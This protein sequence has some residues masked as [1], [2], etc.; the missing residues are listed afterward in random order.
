MEPYFETDLGKLFNGDALEV[1]SGMESESVQCCITSPPYWGLRDYGTATWEGGDL[2]CNHEK[3]INK[4]K[5]HAGTGLNVAKNPEKMQTEVGGMHSHSYRD[6]CKKCGAKRIDQQL[7]LEK[8]PEEY[9]SKMV[10]IF[11]EVRRVLRKDGTLWLNLG[12]SYYNNFGGGSETMTTGNAP[13]VKARGR[14]N[15]PKHKTLKIK[16]LCGIPWRVAFALQADGWWLRQD[17]IW[18]LSGGTWIYARTQKGDMPMMLKDLY[19]LNPSTIKLWN[20]EKWTQLLGM[21]KAARTG[22]EIELVL[23]SGER[24]SCTG[25]HKFPTNRGLLEASNIKV[26]DCLE[27]TFIP[28]PTLPKKPKHITYDAAWFAGLYLAE[29]SKSGN[30]IQI[31]GHAK[32]QDRWNR[33]CNIVKDYGGYITRTISGNKMDIRIW[34]NVLHAILDELV[35]GRT[36]K[37]KCLSTTCWNYS[38]GF[39]K[40]L[41][42]GYLSGDGGWDESN[43]RWRLGFT[44][45]YNLERDIRVLAARLEFNLT[46]NLSNSFIKDKKYPSFRGEIKFEATAEGHWNQK[47]KLEVVEIR[48][49][50]CRYVYDIGVEDSHLFA[51][52]SGVLTH[53]SKPNPMPESVT[54]RCT[55][56]HEYIFLM[57]KSAKYYYDNEA[58]KEKSIWADKDKRFI[59]GPT[60]GLK[61]Q[62]GVYAMQSCGAYSKS[63]MKNKR[64][65]WTVATKP[66]K[67]AHFAT[68]PPDLIL[69]C[70][71]AGTSEKGCCVECGS[72]WERV[73]DK[74]QIPRVDVYEGSKFRD[75]ENSYSHKRL[76]MMVKAGREAGLE[77][78]NP[79]LPSKTIGWQPT[80][81]CKT[82]PTPDLKPCIILDPFAGSGTVWEVCEKYNRKSVNT[83]L[84]E[85]YCQLIKKRIKKA[86]RQLKLF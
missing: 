76:Q 77:H 37:D 29:G 67:E 56:S 8:T 70:I 32:E 12:D 28:E 25:N 13:A 23:R 74:P 39:L 7:G 33:L 15:K 59:N 60:K 11:R 20:G 31:A 47:N 36:A 5:L 6:V 78:D 66:Y 16:D 64:S 17:I 68:F 65:V 69:P 45:N 62:S 34:G 30:C 9:V 49:A 41:L 44:R 40:T 50:R 10:E 84:S 55:K 71:L 81:K 24:I 43:K 46:L 53:N 85:E 75:K 58:I 35:S 18:C 2:N 3:P 4:A 51:L 82:K 19:R 73:V 42:D 83:E 52:A 22:N 48:K 79:I 21:S 1:L 72:P 57:S 54:D 80:C 14:D 61:V 86:T 38:N 63:G 26:G 27:S